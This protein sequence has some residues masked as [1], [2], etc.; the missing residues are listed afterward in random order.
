MTPDP[1]SEM[2]PEDWHE[3]MDLA[4]RRD[5][6]YDFDG[7]VRDTYDRQVTDDDYIEMEENEVER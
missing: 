6:P 2:T 3:T 1:E 7:F 4:Q 5:D